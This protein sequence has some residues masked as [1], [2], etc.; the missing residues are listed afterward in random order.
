MLS[1]QLI[2]REHMLYP[3]VCTDLSKSLEQVH[4]YNGLIIMLL[5]LLLVVIN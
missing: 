5:L 1:G 2:T 4:K 3:A